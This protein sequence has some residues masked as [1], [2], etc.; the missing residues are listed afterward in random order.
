M[1]FTALA[2]KNLAPLEVISL[3]ERVQRHS[4]DC[5]GRRVMW[6]T[7]GQGRPLVLL[8]G[9]H[10]SWLH[11]VRNMPALAADRT[12]CVP[13]MPGYG[14]SDEPVKDS[15]EGL[16]QG[17]RKSLDLLLGLDADFDLVGFSF[18]GLVA[19]HLAV[20]NGGVGRMALLGAV[21]HGGVRRPRAE[22]YNWRETALRGDESALAEAMH[23]NLL[24]H[25]LHDPHSVDATALYLHSQA[26][27]LTRFR[28]KSHSLA[29][30]LQELLP[31]S[32]DALLL[33][34]GEHD[35]TADPPLAAA[36]LSTYHPYVQ[37]SIICGAGHW[38]QYESP[39][40]V[41]NLLRVWLGQKIHFDK[42]L[43]HVRN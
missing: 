16:V 33:A 11:W 23:H 35:V 4:I 6:R 40:E 5:G 39:D 36:Q 9:G 29:G 17:L 34:W 27:L 1:S 15:M 32:A 13:D 42:D 41:N 2:T 28:S 37:T 31:R 3:S 22:L 24:A 26:C 14:D 8:H 20:V 25:M 7:L 21:G 10:G 30:G 38:V 43:D 12:V 19:S 18:G